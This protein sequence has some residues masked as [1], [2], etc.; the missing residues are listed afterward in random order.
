MIICVIE[1]FKRQKAHYIRLQTLKEETLRQV[2]AQTYQKITELSELQ[3]LRHK[4]GSLTAMRMLR[5]SNASPSV[6]LIN[7][8]ENDFSESQM[9]Q[10]ISALNLS[11]ENVITLYDKAEYEEYK[12]QK[13]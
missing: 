6:E 3:K 9:D 13:E 1:S 5:A 4:I 11:D 10:P 12:A 7:M 2:R 8:Q